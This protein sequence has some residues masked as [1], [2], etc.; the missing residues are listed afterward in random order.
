M[1]MQQR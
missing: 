1:Q